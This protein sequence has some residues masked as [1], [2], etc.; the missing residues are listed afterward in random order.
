[1]SSVEFVCD[2]RLAL[3]EI[4][5]EIVAANHDQF[6]PY[7][8]IVGE[9][10]WARGVELVAVFKNYG[11][12]INVPMRST[13]GL[14]GAVAELMGGGGHPN[15]AA[16]RCDSHDIEREKAKLIETFNNY[17]SGSDHATL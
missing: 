17:T 3:A 14:A 5:P 11:T 6:E 16:Y 10:Q 7:N 15:A 4:T 13:A 9:M 8:M 12:K 2:G 1:L